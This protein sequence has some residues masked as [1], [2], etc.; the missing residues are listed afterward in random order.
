[1]AFQ[2]SKLAQ[3]LSTL[4]VL[5]VL[6][7]VVLAPE[8]AQARPIEEELR[9]LIDRHPKIRESENT[10]ESR[11]ATI[12]ESEAGYYPTVNIAGEIG[13]QTV[14]TASTR[15]DEA[16]ESDP[17]RGVLNSATLT[18]TQ[19]IFDGFATSATVRIAEVNHEIAQLTL[20]GTRQNT[21]F[22][23]VRAYVDVLRQR[24]LVE[25][26]ADNERTIQRQ[27]N[28]EDERVRRGSGVT[29][30]VLQAKS[31]LQI[32]KERRVGFEGALLN[33]VSTY[34]QV[35][36]HPPNLP[37][38]LDPTPPAQVIPSSLERSVDIALAENPSLI[39][40][41]LNVELAH[42]QRRSSNSGFYPS[43]DL[44]GTANYEK[45]NNA[46]NG[47]RRD[48]S[49]I[50]SASWDVF[51]GGSTLAGREAS[52][53]D[54]RAQMNNY[55]YTSTKVIEQVRLSWQSLVTSRER[56]ELLG[57]AVNIAAEVFDSRKKLRD[58]GKETVINV[59]DAENEVNNAQINYATS[60]YDE[61]VAIYQ[62]LLSMG[63]MKPQ[64]IVS[65]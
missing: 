38:M 18:V 31:R 4:T 47:I 54:Y 25:M 48:Y 14:D 21:L 33:A 44:T 26:A 12:R 64:Y 11:R 19:P 35:F 61:R 42:E 16:N 9:V 30:D 52:E 3:S 29:V 43:L 28:L 34:E 41:S 6:G 8:G 60:S 62:L 7:P 40:G 37:T 27:L 2:S 55:E 39:G 20:E 5:A 45:K 24:R 22:E 46:T 51:S 63:R 56:K 32:A 49:V 65:Q 50:M 53:F 58:A 1:M 57:N 23:G 59:L 10:L 15:S 17:W 36:G 13:P